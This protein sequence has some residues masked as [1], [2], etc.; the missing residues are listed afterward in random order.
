[1]HNQPNAYHAG[2]N[3]L[4]VLDR[5]RSADTVE[6]AAR[7]Q[8]IHTNTP[9]TLLQAKFGQEHPVLTRATWLAERPTHPYAPFYWDWVVKKGAINSM[10]APGQQCAPDLFADL[11]AASEVYINGEPTEVT[12]LNRR[13]CSQELLGDAPKAAVVAADLFRIRPDLWIACRTLVKDFDV[14]EDEGQL[15]TDFL[16]SHVVAGDSDPKATVLMAVHPKSAAVTNLSLEQLWG[17]SHVGNGEWKSEDGM[18]IAL[19]GQKFNTFLAKLT[20]R[21]AAMH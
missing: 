14:A 3:V 2:D 8:A 17:F 7:S 5:Q 21:K 12:F 11:L 4:S 15:L 13:A 20:S 18:S 10:E 9:E 6:H 16:E 19:K 1:M